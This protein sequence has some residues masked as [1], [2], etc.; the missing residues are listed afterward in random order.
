MSVGADAIVVDAPTRGDVMV[1]V[2]GLV[3]P[4]LELSRSSKRPRVG[5]HVGVLMNRT[6]S[7]V[8]M[9]LG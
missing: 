4:A 9:Y 8:L 2:G 7:H 6:H 1:Q 5:Q 3:A